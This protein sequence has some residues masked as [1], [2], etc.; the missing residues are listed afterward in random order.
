[1]SLGDFLYALNLK[2]ARTQPVLQ[3]VLRR[4]QVTL[5]NTTVTANLDPV[6]LEL[7]W[8]VTHLNVNQ[9]AGAA[10]TASSFRV[11]IED[12]NG[13]FLATVWTST[14]DAAAVQSRSAAQPV[15]FYLMPRERLVV[16]GFFSAGANPNTIALD[17]F[18]LFMPRGTLQLR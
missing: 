11:E 14:P 18:G 15:S 2:E 5:A 17:A 9:I 7:I 16:D 6:P 12:E 1:M 13:N 8:H 3:R 4:Q 10:Q